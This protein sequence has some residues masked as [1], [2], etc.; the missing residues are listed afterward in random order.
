MSQLYLEDTITVIIAK[1]KSYCDKK[2]DMTK[3]FKMLKEKIKS[4]HYNVSQL[5]EQDIIRVILNGVMN[6]PEMK[7]V[8]FY[9]D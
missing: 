7:E 5:V 6:N 8:K 4:K 3:Y 9:K 2:K 1:I